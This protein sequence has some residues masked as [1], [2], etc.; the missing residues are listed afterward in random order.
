ME[1]ASLSQKPGNA[2]GA[3]LRLEVVRVNEH[4]LL[5]IITA[6]GKDL[7]WWQMGARAV[8]TYFITMIII[9]LG[10]KRLFGK[11]AAMDVV[12]GVILGSVMSRAI[13]GSSTLLPAAVAT[14]V[15]VF[16]HALSAKLAL[17]SPAL[18]VLLK[19]RP[20]LLVKDGTPLKDSLHRSDISEHDL[21]EAL[22]MKGQRPDLAKIEEAH[23]ERN[24]NVSIIPK[25]E[26]KV[27]EIKVE[28]GVQTVRL[29][30]G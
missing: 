10:K 3:R 6:E 30:V 24:G 12:L 26:P 8:L 29:E 20:H 19:G 15:L 23:M 16:L 5:Q 7:D 18:G 2:D 9:R 1:T 28:N 25:K 21:E 22:R 14:L 17:L 11:S 27:I 13:N 4:D